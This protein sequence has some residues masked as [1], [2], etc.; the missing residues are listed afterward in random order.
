MLLKRTILEGVSTLVYD[1]YDSMIDSNVLHEV[2]SISINS[3]LSVR[4]NKERER[5]KLRI[6]WNNPV[7]DYDLNQVLRGWVNISERHW[8]GILEMRVD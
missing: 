8:I 7:D 2:E 6:F 4:I 3:R 5:N 1:V